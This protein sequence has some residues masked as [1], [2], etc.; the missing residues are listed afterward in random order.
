M[1]KGVNASDGFGIGVAQVAVAPDI[2]FTPVAPEDPEKEKQRYEA[3]LEKFV[4]QTNAQ[5]ERMKVSV[6]EEAALIMGAHIEFAEDEGIHD[7]V[8]SSIDAGMCAEQ[9][10]SEAYNTYYTMFSQMDDELFRERATDVA[11][12]KTGLLA[13]LLGKEVVDLS[14]LPENSIIVVKE[15]TPSM[16]ADIDKENVA[17]IVTETGGRTSHSAIIARALEIPAVLSVEDATEHIKTGDMVIVDGSAGD[18]LVQPSKEDLEAYRAKAKAY[19]DDKAALETY[20]GKK[21]ITADGET[22]L[23]VANI[24]NPDDANAAAEHDAEGIGL[25]RSEFLF[26]DAKELPS[27][28]EQFA[29]YQKVALRMKGHPII[30]R[31]LDVGGDKE[32]PYMNLQKEDNPFMGFRAIRYCLNNPDQYKVQLTAL[33]RASAFGDIKIMLP[34]VTSLDE[35]RKARSLVEECKKELDERGVSYDPD[36]EV[37]TMIETPAASLIADNLAEVCD[38]FSIG[39]NDLIGYTMCADRGNDRVAYLYEVYQPAVLRS[40]KRIIS[41]GNKRGIMVGMCGEAAADPLLIPV[42]ISFG[43]GE[44]SVSAPSI[45]RTRRIISQW[46]KEEADVLTEKVLTLKTAAEVKAA[47]QAA[48]K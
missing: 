21:T 47:L 36:I 15:L 13:D 17:G 20:R 42:L 43:L 30:I 44:F 10:V 38:F 9:A 48:A 27:E 40:L 14:T 45:L 34:L 31:T 4:A 22:K 2:S 25:F 12:V 46:T 24:G 1:F 29:A 23:L 33:L 28:D 41:E 35:V 16:T 18:V 3:A 6:G 19:A 11:D 37:G 8:N 32:I 5:I 26:M 39:T 7:T